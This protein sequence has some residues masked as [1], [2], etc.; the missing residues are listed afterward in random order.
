MSDFDRMLDRQIEYQQED[1]VQMDSEYFRSEVMR[2]AREMLDT[3]HGLT[4]AQKDRYAEYL[5]SL[6]YTHDSPAPRSKMDKVSNLLNSI[7]DLIEAAGSRDELADA[8]GTIYQWIREHRESTGQEQENQECP[9]VD[10][11]CKDGWI[12]DESIE[13]ESQQGEDYPSGRSEVT[14]IQSS[15]KSLQLDRRIGTGREELG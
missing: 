2:I 3:T 8:T 7:M 12:C 5:I 1:E 10:C 15:D 13:Q 6:A 14:I 9:Y 4:S 11:S